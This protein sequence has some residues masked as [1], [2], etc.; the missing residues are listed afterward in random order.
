MGRVLHELPAC[1]HSRA[2]RC[3]SFAPWQ[4]M[5]GKCPAAM[6]HV[7]RG[8]ITRLPDEQMRK[9]GSWHENRT[10]IQITVKR[11]MASMSGFGH[12]PDTGPSGI[13]IVRKHAL[14]T[15]PHC[16]LREPIA[17]APKKRNICQRLVFHGRPRQPDFAWCALAC[18]CAVG[19]CTNPNPDASST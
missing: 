18:A 5:H 9:Q 14:S 13:S 19:S 10:R 15:M 12:L 3:Q 6:M 17:T 1:W 8:L 16:I 4:V 2:R 7:A 11:S